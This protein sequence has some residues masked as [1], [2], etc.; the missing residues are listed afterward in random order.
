[1]YYLKYYRNLWGGENVSFLYFLPDNIQYYLI[2]PIEYNKQPIAKY[3][4]QFTLAL[5]PIGSNTENNII[6]SLITETIHTLETPY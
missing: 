6:T 2:T 1:M 3:D 4:L 5:S